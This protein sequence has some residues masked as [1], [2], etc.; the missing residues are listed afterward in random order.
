MEKAIQIIKKQ[1]PRERIIAETFY[2]VEPSTVSNRKLFVPG[3]TL[4]EF[5][6]DRPWLK[7][8]SQKKNKN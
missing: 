4:N 5:L 6:L 3:C 1:M 8:I 2:T 7:K